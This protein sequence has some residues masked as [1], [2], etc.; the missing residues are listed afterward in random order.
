MK[1]APS[2]LAGLL[3]AVCSC[4][5][6]SMEEE[7]V[8]CSHEVKKDSG[9]KQGWSCLPLC[10]LSRGWADLQCLRCSQ[11]HLCLEENGLFCEKVCPTE[12]QG[13]SW[14]ARFSDTITTDWMGDQ[15]PREEESEPGCC[16]AQGCLLPK[17]R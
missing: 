11:S 17:P 9:N 12:P 4:L 7:P 2:F 16:S 14:E 1:M 10:S 6:F 5:S 13:Q 15:R 8:T 3:P